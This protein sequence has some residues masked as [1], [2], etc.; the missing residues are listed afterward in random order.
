MNATAPTQCDVL[1]KGWYVVS[2]N[3]D[4]DIIRNGAVAITGST[5]VG[6]GKALDLEKQFSPKRVINKGSIISL[7]PIPI[8]S[9][10]EKVM[11]LFIYY[12]FLR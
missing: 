3:A 4:R 8:D 1:V 10:Q 2:M 6:V 5:I 12:F 11:T 7:N 9:Y